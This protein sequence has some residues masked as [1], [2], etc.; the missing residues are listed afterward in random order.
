[1]SEVQAQLVDTLHCAGLDIQFRESNWNDEKNPMAFVSIFPRL[2]PSHGLC[3]HLGF[4]AQ[5][6]GSVY[7]LQPSGDV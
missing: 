3:Q 1:M 5:S 2:D 6:S 4:Q 7:T